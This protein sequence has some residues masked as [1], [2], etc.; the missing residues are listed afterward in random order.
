MSDLRVFPTLRSALATPDV[1]W[2]TLY[3]LTGFLPSLASPSGA[4][5]IIAGAFLRAL[6]AE[7]S[8]GTLRDPSDS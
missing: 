4:L 3:S 8:L 6:E 7:G 1:L 5:R 2:S